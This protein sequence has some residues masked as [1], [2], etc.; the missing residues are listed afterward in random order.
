M[1]LTSEL[2]V[3]AYA[4]GFFPMAEDAGSQTL[5]WFDPDPRGILPL[6]AFHVPKKLRRVVRNAVYRVQVDT[7]FDLVLAKC[8]PARPGGEKTWL[9]ESIA[10]TCRE[11]HRL[12]FAHSVE[13]WREGTLVGGLYGVALGGAFFGESMFSEADN[14]SKVALVHLV[15]R[16][17][18]SG[19][20]L[21]D[22]Q[23]VTDHLRQFGAVEI[24][25]ATYRRLLNEALEQQP[26]F[27]FSYRAGE[28][29][30]EGEGAG[31]AGGIGSAGGGA[32]T[33]PDAGEADAEEAALVASF[34]QSRTQMS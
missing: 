6:D 20:S 7:A 29:E 15:A 17:V 11:L 10:R 5:H 22:T 8:G 4:A 12:G 13:A 3:R 9:N 30:G 34:L 31:A 1:E 2:M 19:F 24:P 33:A 32:G 25:R 18:A 23:F 14:A 27:G 21:L 28:G 16:L 26:R